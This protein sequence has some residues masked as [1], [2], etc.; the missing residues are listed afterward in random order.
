MLLTVAMNTVTLTVECTNR[1]FVLES[2]IRTRPTRTVYLISVMIGW[3]WEIVL[4]G[5]ITASRGF[6]QENL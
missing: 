5:F 6:S 1:V 2:C 3:F 4:G